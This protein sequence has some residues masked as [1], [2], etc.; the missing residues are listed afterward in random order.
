MWPNIK[1]VVN[2]IV[3]AALSL[4]VPHDNAATLPLCLAVIK[5]VSFSSNKKKKKPSFSYC[6]LGIDMR[7]CTLT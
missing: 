4:K 5:C 3:N 7:E 2:L 1:R 6:E